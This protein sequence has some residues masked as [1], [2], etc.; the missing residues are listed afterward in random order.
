MNHILPWIVFNRKFDIFSTQ[1]KERKF[2]EFPSLNWQ[3]MSV[4][5]ENTVKQNPVIGEMKFREIP[6]ISDVR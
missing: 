5:E 6:G 3:L 2:P 1:V 4:K